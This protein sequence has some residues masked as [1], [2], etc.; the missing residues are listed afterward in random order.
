MLGLHDTIKEQRNKH[1]K[2][3]EEEVEE[4]E[5]MS[6]SREETPTDAWSN[7]LI[8]L[9]RGRIQAAYDTIINSRIYIYI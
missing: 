1:T 9:G 4:E 8:H 2:Q 5:S 7:A 6:R 3:A